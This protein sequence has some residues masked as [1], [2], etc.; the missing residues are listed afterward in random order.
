MDVPVPRQSTRASVS[1]SREPVAVSRSRL[2]AL[3]HPARLGAVDVLPDH[4]ALERQPDQPSMGLL[5]DEQLVV[6]QHLGQALIGA[7]TSSRSRA[8]R[9]GEVTSPVAKS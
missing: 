2:Q 1:A 3:E 4:I 8:A 6:R 5:L 7:H 9:Q